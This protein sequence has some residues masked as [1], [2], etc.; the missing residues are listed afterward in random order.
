[1]NNEHQPSGE[2]VLKEY[3]RSTRWMEEKQVIGAGNL[4]LTT[5]RLIFLHQV[6]L[7]EKQSEHVRKLSEEA[8]TSKLIDHALTLHKN[9]FQFPLSSIT[10]AKTGLFSIL[11]FP[12]PCL[13]IS[14]ISGKKKKMKTVSF[15]FTIPLLKGF[16]Q[17]EF[18]T[19]KAWVLLINK[20][21]RQ[22]QMGA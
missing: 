12:R 11:P 18:A 15:M 8:T 20:A 10:K 1:M 5:E 19:V 14:Y 9:N 17:T 2:A 4:I 3:P 22:K 21:V 6:A 13:R 16:F 7:T